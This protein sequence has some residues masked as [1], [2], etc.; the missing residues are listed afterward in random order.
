MKLL[1][2]AAL[3]RALI[4]LLTAESPRPME[5]SLTDEEELICQLSEWYGCVPLREE[6]RSHLGEGK[7]VANPL[8]KKKDVQEWG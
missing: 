5:W 2:L 1:C 4:S 3:L 7:G 6:T 8:P